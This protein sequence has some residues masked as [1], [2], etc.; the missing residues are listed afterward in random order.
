MPALDEVRLLL[1]PILGAVIPFKRLTLHAVHRRAVKRG[2]IGQKPFVPR[3]L[4]GQPTS[5]EHFHTFRYS[6]K[7]RNLLPGWMYETDMLSEG[8][9]V[10]NLVI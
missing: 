10:H 2:E 7:L 8:V 9:G 3:F 1:A 4:P 6:L 5:I